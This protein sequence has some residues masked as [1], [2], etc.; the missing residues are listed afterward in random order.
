MR[1]QAEAGE[2]ALAALLGERDVVDAAADHVRVDV[3]VEIEGAADQLAGP[4][5]RG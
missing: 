4:L 5:G 2:P 1:L 3:D